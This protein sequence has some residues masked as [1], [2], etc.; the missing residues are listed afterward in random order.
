M[1]HEDSNL[2]L[3]PTGYHTDSIFSKTK[4]L[5]VPTAALNGIEA[6]WGRRAQKLHREDIHDKIGLEGSENT[7]PVRKGLTLKG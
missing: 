1:Q 7:L 6:T 4:I 3:L 2:H 5:E